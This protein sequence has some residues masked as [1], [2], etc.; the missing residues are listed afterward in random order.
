MVAILPL[1]IMQLWIFFWSWFFENLSGGGEMNKVHYK[2][3][4]PKTDFPFKSYDKKLVFSKKWAAS[5]PTRHKGKKLFFP[6]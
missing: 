1:L 3:F 6:N 4:L 5:F 2:Q